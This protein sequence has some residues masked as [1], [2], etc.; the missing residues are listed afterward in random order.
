MAFA[1]SY[2]HGFDVVRQR[3][4][5]ADLKDCGEFE[6]LEGASI[7]II[8]TRAQR[9]AIH[10]FVLRNNTLT[11]PFYMFDFS[12]KLMGYLVLLL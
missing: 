11:T 10:K 5:D 7:D 9:D 4:Q 3:V 6:V 12:Q 2:M 8:L 1:T